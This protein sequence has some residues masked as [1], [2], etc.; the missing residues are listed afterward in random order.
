MECLVIPGMTRK[1][2][3]ALAQA[4]RLNAPDTN[5]NAYEAE[6]ALFA[7]IVRDVSRACASANGRFDYNRFERASGLTEIKSPK[8]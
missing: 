1:H 6:A 7:N 3:I 2:F 8:A 5:S 4:L